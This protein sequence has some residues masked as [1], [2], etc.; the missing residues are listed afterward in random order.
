MTTADMS[1]APSRNSADGTYSVYVTGNVAYIVNQ[2]ASEPYKPPVRAQPP[3]GQIPVVIESK[4]TVTKRVGT[5]RHLCVDQK[6][7]QWRLSF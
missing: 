3:V 6:R 2:E 7:E 4:P 1:T 5:L